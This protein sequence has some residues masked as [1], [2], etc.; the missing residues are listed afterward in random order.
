MQ[1]RDRERLMRRPRKR[2]DH[3]FLFSLIHPPRSVMSPV[4][5]KG[6]C[7]SCLSLKREMEEDRLNLDEKREEKSREVV[8]RR[9]KDNESLSKHRTN[10]RLSTR[11]R[12]R[13]CRGLDLAR[14]HGAF[15][16]EPWLTSGPLIHVHSFF[17]LI[18]PNNYH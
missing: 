14:F 16:L 5:L 3:V 15:P 2:I 4:Q 17:C 18:K 7:S 1:L 12:V 8:R 6:Q 10:Q 13:P 11:G 9:G